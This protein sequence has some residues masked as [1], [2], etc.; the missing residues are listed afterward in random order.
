M[1]KYITNKNN[2]LWYFYTDKNEELLSEKIANYAI[3]SL[4]I[5]KNITNTKNIYKIT[6][7]LIL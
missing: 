6:E 3:E 5:L 7:K 2:A 4:F 1:T